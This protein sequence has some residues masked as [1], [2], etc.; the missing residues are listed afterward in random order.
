MTLVVGNYRECGTAG[1]RNLDLQIIKQMQVIKPDSIESFDHLNVVCGSGCH[2]YL[3]ASAVKG[4][5]MAIADRGKQLIVNSAFR[6]FA[7]QLILYQHY[8]AR[9]CGVLAAASPGHSNHN[10][11]LAIDI[12]DSLGWRSHLSKYGWR[13]IGSFDPM[14]Y[15][16][17]G[18]GNKDLT[19]LSI[20]A[21]QQLYNYAH[22]K[23]K[24]SADGYYGPQTLNALKGTSVDGFVI[25]PFQYD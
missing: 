7:Q 23:N 3:Q 25:T 16:F 6:T 4:L 10:G 12:E 9:R 5:E 2:P 15:D 13:W 17:K 14:H 11:A 19:S 24:I 1:I 18:A 8:L 22:P 21:F 20:L